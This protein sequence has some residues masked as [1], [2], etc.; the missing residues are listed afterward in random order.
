[1]SLPQ[2]AWWRRL[3]HGRGFG[4]HSPFAY[5]FIREVLRE[6]C[7]Y[8]GYTT[9]DAVADAWPGGRRS[10]RLLLRV[11]AFVQPRRVL[12]ACPAPMAA[13]AGRIVATTVPAAAQTPDAC[14]DADFAIVGSTADTDAA[15]RIAAAGG[16]L[17]VPQRS[18][19]TDAL[20]RRIAAELPFGHIYANGSGTAIY[21]G[22]HTLPAEQF[23]VRF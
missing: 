18:E 17:F 13:A 22:R 4:V 11:S 2:P 20:L 5:R 8:Y 10:A 3:R 19:A 12:L 14:P 1:M 6:R 15:F 7:A 23:D 9:A 16:T 21:I